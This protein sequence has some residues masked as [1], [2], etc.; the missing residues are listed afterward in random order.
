MPFEFPRPFT[1]MVP[2]LRVPSPSLR[3]P[4]PPGRGPQSSRKTALTLRERGDR[5]ALSE[6]LL[7]SRVR[8]S[9]SEISELGRRRL[10]QNF[11]CTILFMAT[12]LACGIALARDYL[13]RT[14]LPTNRDYA[15]TPSGSAAPLGRI[16]YSEKC[17]RTHE[18]AIIRVPPSASPAINGVA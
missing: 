7:A 8:H 1:N 3:P 5:E 4:S 10:I 15:R 13:L 16:T 12:L 11:E 17:Q 6:G 9:D 14:A 2:Y 18:I